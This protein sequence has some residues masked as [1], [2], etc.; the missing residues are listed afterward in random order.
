MRK[1]LESSC[2]ETGGDRRV[3]LNGDDVTLKIRT[4]E[5][6]HMASVVSTIPEIREQL[7]KRQQQIARRASEGAILDGRD[8]G[9]VVFPDADF[10][11]FLTAD[12]ENRARRRYYEDKDR[13]RDVT[14]EQTLAENPGTG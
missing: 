14:F 9:T 1:D 8:I 12:S 6:S 5:V 7:V 4:N 13:G 11:F 3:L 2:R 10:K